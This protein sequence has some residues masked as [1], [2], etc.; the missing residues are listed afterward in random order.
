MNSIIAES[1]HFEILIEISTVI[2]A[3]QM[4]KQIKY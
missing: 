1:Y 4:N 3:T 2:F